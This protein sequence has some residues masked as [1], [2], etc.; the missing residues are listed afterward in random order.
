MGLSTVYFLTVE[1]L[2]TF[3]CFTRLENLIVRWLES[4]WCHSI[5]KQS[6]LYKNSRVNLHYY[7]N[8]ARLYTFTSGYERQPNN[9]RQMAMAMAA[10]GMEKWR[11]AKN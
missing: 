1:L 2:K 10:I 6:Y 3:C 9:E 7:C 5:I 8:V 11:K 4:N